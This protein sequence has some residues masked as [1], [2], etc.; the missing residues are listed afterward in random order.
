MSRRTFMKLKQKTKFV[1]FVNKQL[2]VK[3]SVTN[4][5]THVLYS[6]EIGVKC[7]VVKLKTQRKGKLAKNVVPGI[8]IILI[9]GVKLFILRGIASI[10][11]GKDN[12]EYIITGLLQSY[13]LFYFQFGYFS[14]GGE[15]FWQKPG[16]NFQ[17]ILSVVE[18][19]FW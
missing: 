6:I 10:K 8:I 9:I 16:L 5:I 18:K 2:T 14:F 4:I 3:L 7:V 13:Y 1:S 19:I 15:I 12:L 17:K 11:T